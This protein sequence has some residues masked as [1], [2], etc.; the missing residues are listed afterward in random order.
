MFRQHYHER[1]PITCIL[2]G[3]NKLTKLIIQAEHLRLLH[4]ETTFMAASLARGF[5]ISGAQHE[6]R[7]ITC[8]CVV[9]QCAAGKTPPRTNPGFV[10]QQVGV[11]YANPMLTKSGHIRISTI[12]KSYILVFVSFSVKVMHLELVSDLSSAAFIATL[13]QFVA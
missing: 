7:A 2:S 1:Y 8:R 11:D 4:A 3:K 13:R 6:I 9:C 10:F 5:H 12:T